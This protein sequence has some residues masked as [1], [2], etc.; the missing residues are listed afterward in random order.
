M[1]GR[2]RGERVSSGAAAQNA[3]ERL[4]LQLKELTGIRNATARDPSFKNW[5][6]ATLTVMERIWPGDQD[7]CE[8]FR[9]IPF[10]P[11]DPRADLRVLR[12]WY[13][14]GCQEAA[15]VLTTFVEDIRANGVPDQTDQNFPESQVSE[16]EDGFPSVDLPAGD[17]ASS[18]NASD[19]SDLAALDDSLPQGSDPSSP[20]PQRLQV[21]MPKPPAPEPSAPVAPV[22]ESRLM[23]KGPGMKARLR[24]LLGF[25]HLSAKAIAGFPREPAEPAAEEAPPAPDMRSEIGVVPLGEDVGPAPK[26][27]PPVLNE[28]GQPKPAWPVLQAPA[29][30][31]ASP[32]PQPVAQQPPAPATPTASTAPPA[33]A[34]PPA[35]S[36]PPVDTPAAEPDPL[37]T[38]SMIM[39]KPTTLRTSI[40]K[41]SIE[42]LISP[43]F[44]SPGGDEAPAAP[45]SPAEPAAPAPA[46]AWPTLGTPSPSEPLPAATETTPPPPPAGT[47]PPRAIVPPVFNDP[48]F[49][50]DAAPSGGSRS[51]ANAAPPGAKPA[52]P[53]AAKTPATPPAGAKKAAGRASSSRIM[54]APTP[55]V[56]VPPPDPEPKVEPEAKA[57][58]TPASEAADAPARSG[59]SEALARATEDFMRSSP[60]LGATGRRVQRGFEDQGFAD[61]DA[62]ALGSMAQDLER[63]GIPAGRQ[64]EVR[65]RLMDLARR[66]EG[67]E[68]EWGMLRKAVWFAMEYPALAQRVMPL[69]LPWIDRAA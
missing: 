36:I 58:S 46:P 42:S 59:D 14:R 69:L 52:A 64:P 49:S 62:I 19:V 68:L 27:R 26:L 50:A 67:G 11:A 33:A 12:E 6:Q 32:A 3:I 35:A 44:R 29:T 65:A 31:P 34:V 17:L 55:P 38:M 9:R 8:R 10:S 37:S 63:L 57:E 16:F 24:D 28:P 20:A 56:R 43:A 21:G 39:T 41:V 45:A 22:S 1:R 4:E 53:P 51:A 23:K 13:S 61:P 40:E 15:R 54:Q 7:R 30:A 18:P 25:A 5:R 66:L 60:V 48:E 47:R 2:A